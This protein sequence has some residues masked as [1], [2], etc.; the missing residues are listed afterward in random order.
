M[1]DRIKDATGILLKHALDADPSFL[2]DQ[3]NISFSD[4]IKFFN[5]RHNKGEGNIPP[6]RKDVI[7]KLQNALYGIV[8][9]N[10]IEESCEDRVLANCLGELINENIDPS[11]IIKGIL[12]GGNTGSNWVINNLVP[13]IDV[14]GDRITKKDKIDDPIINSET[15]SGIPLKITTVGK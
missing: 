13:G 14:V 2:Q 10:T 3:E 5:A 15:P 9:S 12:S 11:L 4:I 6:T 7:R 8:D 1:A